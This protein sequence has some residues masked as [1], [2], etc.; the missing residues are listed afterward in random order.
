MRGK[1]CSVSLIIT[2]FVLFSGASSNGHRMK[3]NARVPS[4]VFFVKKST[5]QFVFCGGETFV[6]VF[7]T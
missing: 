7:F 2:R 4:F 5:Y 3:R 1:A 6:F